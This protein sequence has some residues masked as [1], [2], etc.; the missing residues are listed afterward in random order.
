MAALLKKLLSVQF[1]QK[2]AK[3][4][5]INGARRGFG[6]QEA[7]YLSCLQNIYFFLMM[8]FSQ[9]CRR[10]A[11]VAVSFISENNGD[12]LWEMGNR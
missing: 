7:F 11:A 8:F 9:H 2:M 6:C 3:R 5:R 4:K 12:A 1:I 10:M